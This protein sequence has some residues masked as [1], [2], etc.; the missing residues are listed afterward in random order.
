MITELQLHPLCTLFPRI[1]GAEF[2]ALKSDIA[3]NGLRQPIVV[4][5]G[6]IL[7]GGN[8]YRACIEVGAEP[9]TVEFDGGN[10][11]SYVLSANLHR[12]HMTQG[13]QAAIV[14]S[15]Q[16][17]AKAQVAGRPEKQTLNVTLSTRSERAAASGA[18]MATQRDAD[19]VAKADPNLA[20]Q[21]AHG[22]ISLTKAVKQIAPAKPAAKTAAPATPSPS[23]ES[24]G[25]E[26]GPSDEEIAFL[27][28]TEVADRDAYNNLVE[29]A[30]SDDKLADALALVVTQTHEIARLKALV[31]VIEESR[32][33]KMMTI[34]EQIRTIKSLQRKLEKFEKAAA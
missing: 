27:E 8:R 13:Q 28:A 1:V 4:H 12:R 10:I 30:T 19:R 6:M 34:N 11:V 20:K 29:I 33:G 14:A 15:A 24:E 31:R 32:D 25:E 2:E 21:V 26:F 9:H 17:W 22:K 3:T 7:D 5:K 23:A 16:D 18:S